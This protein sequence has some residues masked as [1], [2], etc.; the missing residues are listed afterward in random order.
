MQ[1]VELNKE[2]GE[3]ELVNIDGS[4]VSSSA[5]VAEPPNAGKVPTTY[6]E[7]LESR[8]ARRI[9]QE[10]Q[11]IEAELDRIS[12]GEDDRPVFA[13]DAGQFFGDLGKIAINAPIALAT[14]YVDLGLGVADVVGQTAQI[15][16]GQPR[17]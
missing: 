13:Q 14:D 12:R 15:L 7:L 10:D 11:E 4:A 3:Y 9:Q 16:T 6:M 17:S 5:A 8:A 1:K 2:T